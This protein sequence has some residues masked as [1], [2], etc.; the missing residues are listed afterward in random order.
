MYGGIDW[1]G[2]KGGFMIRGHM[3]KLTLLISLLFSITLFGCGGGGGGGSSQSGG[4]SPSPSIQVTPSTYNYGTVTPGNSPAPLYVEIKN[5]GAASLNISNISLLDTTNF[6]LNLNGGSNPC[7]SATSKLNAGDRCTVEVIFQPQSTA[8]FSTNLKI[9]SNDTTASTLN[10]PLSGSQED[11]SALNVRINQVEIACPSGVVTTYVSVTDQG[12][13]PVSVLTK[14]DFSIAET[15]GYAGLPASSPFVENNA[16][17]S[18]DVVMD[19]SYTVTKFPDKVSDMQEGAVSFIN[20]LGAGDEAEII[21]FSDIIEVVQSFTSDKNLLISA[22]NSPWAT[23]YDTALYDA[24]KIAL[25]NTALRSNDR[26]AVVLISDG[27]DNRSSYTLTYL[28]NH[29]L[30]QNV[31]FFTVGLGDTVNVVDLEKLA[32]DTGGQYYAAP[33]SDNLQTVYQQLADV[34]F[35]HQYILTYNSGLSDGTTADLTVGATLPL[36]TITGSKTKS[37]TKCP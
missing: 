25:E 5:N 32:D 10:L 33:T 14:D 3:F 21:R 6:A 28:I 22:I 17:I 24:G 36:T 15:G 7:G 35:S 20:Q 19:Y 23:R 1:C 8:P 29:A 9:N 26:K 12:G 4:T 2:Q 27:W 16:T 34:L 30:A 31:P 13:Y 18:A 37:I 11:I